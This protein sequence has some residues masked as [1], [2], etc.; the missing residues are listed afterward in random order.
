V[1]AALAAL[2]V[3]GWCVY[4]TAN[5]LLEGEQRAA[6]F[7]SVTQERSKYQRWLNEARAQAAA[8]H[9]ALEIRTHELDAVVRQVEVRH[10]VMR[11]LMEYAG[12]ASIR[13]AVRGDYAVPRSLWAVVLE[14]S[15]PP[16]VQTTSFEP[17]RAM[18]FMH[19]PEALLGP[20][21][22]QARESVDA[23]AHSGTP[24]DFIAYLNDPI[25]A[26]RVAE[27]SARV[28]AARRM[29]H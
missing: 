19:G 24:S 5:T 10:D 29:E 14:N 18:S 25:L 4:A 11:L 2:G 16:S 22:A 9:A 27:V 28:S 13:G 6:L 17:S 26:E 8:A 1:V 12:G 15:A 3:A 23:P 7:E 21:N 20:G